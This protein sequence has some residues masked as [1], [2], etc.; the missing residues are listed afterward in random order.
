MDITS[1]QKRISLIEKLTKE[2]RDA[3]EMLKDELENEPAY[4]EAADEAKAASNKKKQIKDEIIARDGN[5][6]LVDTVKANSEELAT[7][8]EILSAELA[9]LYRSDN[10]EEITDADG[11]SRKLKVAIRLLP[12]N[13]K[14][15]NRDN[16]GKYTSEE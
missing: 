10:I 13:A 1:I 15:N 5:Q 14:D 8:K 6:K 9:Q 4:T 16:F 11:Q 3:N 7:L 2:I 12:K